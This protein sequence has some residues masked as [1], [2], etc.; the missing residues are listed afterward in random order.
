MND[1]GRAQ[2]A[3]E[4]KADCWAL[5]IRAA[6]RKKGN[7]LPPMTAAVVVQAMLSTTDDRRQYDK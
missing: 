1:D 3:K 5:A 4:R 6:P 7:S 2:L